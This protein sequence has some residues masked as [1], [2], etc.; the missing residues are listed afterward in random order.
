M[1]DKLICAVCL[2][3]CMTAVTLAETIDQGRIDATPGPR[4]IAAVREA[5]DNG[6]QLVINNNNMAG[7]YAV[8]TVRGTA[9]CA[10]HMYEVTYGRGQM[11]NPW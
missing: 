7:F 3:D 2:S 1:T 5:V 9:V 6:K 11:G 8:T 10:G 4:L